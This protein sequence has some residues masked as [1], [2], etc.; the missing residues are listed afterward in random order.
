MKE[1]TTLMPFRLNTIQTLIE[2]FEILT[3]RLFFFE[4]CILRFF[5]MKFFIFLNYFLVIILNHLNKN[6]V[7]SVQSLNV[8]MMSRKKTTPLI[9]EIDPLA[10]AN[11]RASV[12]TNLPSQSW[13]TNT[14]TAMNR[15]H[16]TILK[17]RSIRLLI[18]VFII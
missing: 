16:P 17:N 12:L 1:K 7:F 6:K 3:L 14:P 9:M 4:F 13:M 11:L 10:I 18:G 15:A 8:K 5:R 2:N